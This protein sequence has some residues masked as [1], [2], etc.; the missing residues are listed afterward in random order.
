MGRGLP[1]GGGWGGVGAGLGGAETPPFI[2]IVAP[3][4]LS[5]YT[6][7]FKPF[8]PPFTDI[9][10]IDKH[11]KI[12]GQKT[13]NCVAVAIQVAVAKAAVLLVILAKILLVRVVVLVVIT[14]VTIKTLRK[15]GSFEFDRAR[16]QL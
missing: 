12:E 10:K 1:R 8:R 6:P 4:K 15:N 5:F 13:L 9:K 3:S 11:Q 16:V 7:P 2:L 14:I